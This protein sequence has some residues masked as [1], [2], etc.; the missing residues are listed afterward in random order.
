AHSPGDLFHQRE[1][2]DLCGRLISFRAPHAVY[3]PLPVSR[4]SK[5]SSR[6]EDGPKAQ[7]R[8]RTVQRLGGT[9]KTR[10]FRLFSRLVFFRSL[11]E[12]RASSHSWQYDCHQTA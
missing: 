3:P 9:S 5:N 8:G 2:H 4:L 11:L 7:K 6:A 10:A 12:E 1:G